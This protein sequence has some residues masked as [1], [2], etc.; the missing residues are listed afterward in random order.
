[1]NLPPLGSVFE[2][3][4]ELRDVLGQGGFATVYLAADRVM[5]RDVVLKILSPD[6]DG[7]AKSASARFLREAKVFAQLHDPHT[8]TLFDFGESASG[9]RFM[10]FEHVRG[11]DLTAVLE[12]E[13][14][15]EPGAVVH[16]LKQ[17]LS[18]LRE[19]HGLGVF[20]RDIKPANILVFT[21]GQDPYRVKLLDFGIAKDLNPDAARITRTGHVLGTPRYMAPEQLLGEAT[22]ATS[23][24]YSL[25]LVASEMLTG[26][27][28]IP[29]K[30]N[31]E[32]LLRQI[33]AQPLRVGAEF[34][35]LALREV[36]ER[37]M[38]RDP[39]NRPPTAEQALADLRDALSRATVA[40]PQPDRTPTPSVDEV[41]APSAPAPP[42]TAP[43]P[44]ERRTRNV[45]PAVLFGFVA[46]TAGTVSVL[47]P[48]ESPPPPVAPEVVV[49]PGVLVVT[50]PVVVEQ[51]EPDAAT[52]DIA[53]APTNARLAG[54][55]QPAPFSGLGRLGGVGGDSWDTYLPEGYDPDHQH[56]LVLMYHRRLRTGRSLIADS[57][58]AAV[59]DANG[60]VVIAPT[61]SGAMAWQAEH[62]QPTEDMVHY[63]RGRLCLD[64]ARLYAI[65][66]EVG[67]S[68]VR[69][70]ACHMPLSAVAVNTGG[71][72]VTCEPVV[73][74]AR[75]RLYGLRDKEIPPTGGWGCNPFGGEFASAATIDRN[76]KGVHQCEGPDQ[77]WGKFPGGECRTWDCEF[78]PLV[79]C[80]TNGGHYW[81]GQTGLI[82]TERCHVEPAKVEFP[83]AEAIWK[84]FDTEGTLLTY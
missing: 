72:G 48:S 50:P 43:E 73:A 22:D 13:V 28:A 52:P 46:A 31:K 35:P 21:Y 11:E 53:E 5:Q 18:A 9:L 81:P 68:F 59:A 7:Y 70:L 19:A 38:A 40:Q 63:A 78:A 79:T 17:L 37:M 20:H 80:A 33:S 39:A 83:Y 51:A 57:R 54:C 15:L 2:D 67:G 60:F 4:Y 10:V 56:P 77:K 44:T 30:S 24:L 74:T 1:M 71:T 29:G 16:V 23:D 42:L 32:I 69:K 41:P 26:T 12:R 49:P 27:P 84:F 64:P 58:I 61:A 45:W 34:A 66:D 25:G 47:G 8:V 14:R 36:I 75:M 76:W 82:D 65:G 62:L 3:R 6:E 55:G